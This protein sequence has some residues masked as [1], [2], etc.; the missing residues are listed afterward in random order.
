MTKISEVKDVNTAQFRE[1]TDI[2]Q[3]SIPATE[4]QSIDTLKQRI[5]SGKEKLYI[6]EKDG[7]VAM[8]ALLY[9]LEAT[10]F[11]LLDY[12]AVK[13]EHRKHGVGSEFLKK[14]YDITGFKNKLFLIEVEDPKIGTEEEQQTRQRRVYF[15]RKN[16]AK[17]L[18]NLH[19]VLPPLQGTTPTD[20]ILLVIS[21][22]N[23][24]IWLAGEALKEAIVQIYEELYG[25]SESD[26]LLAPVLASIEKQVDLT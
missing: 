21:P 17:I 2:Y 16:G 22:T 4:R 25:R 18:K 14:I 15:Y 7:K 26:P 3:Q 6:A 1:A 13:E 19:Y 12:M 10:Q 5:S 20:M 11:V 8:M 24:L 9:P 23:R